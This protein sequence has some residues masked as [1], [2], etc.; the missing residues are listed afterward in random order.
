MS[1]PS[2]SSYPC[3]SSSS[4]GGCSSLGGVAACRGTTRD[5][6]VGTGGAPPLRPFLTGPL[7]PLRPLRRTI[8]AEAAALRRIH[9]TEESERGRLLLARRQER[10]SVCACVCGSEGRGRVCERV[11]RRHHTANRCRTLRLSPPNP[12]CCVRGALAS[13]AGV[14]A[15]RSSRG[16]REREKARQL[17]TCQER[18]RM[19]ESGLA[20]VCFR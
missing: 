15:P 2:S 18:G 17:E 5:G 3:A 6:V 8:D 16:G 1:P 19:G 10:A 11:E 4:T 13:L 20:F 14:A 7:A 12:R 9:T